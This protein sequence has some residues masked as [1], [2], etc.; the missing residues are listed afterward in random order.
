[1]DTCN[2]HK[3][4]AGIHCL[5][6]EEARQ[7]I[8]QGWQFIAIGSELKMLLSGVNDVM[9]KLGAGQGKGEMAKY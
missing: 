9:Q 1:M 3:V 2:K 8:E 7:R 6:A 5:S 4:A